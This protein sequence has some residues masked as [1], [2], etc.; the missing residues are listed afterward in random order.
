MRIVV[1]STFRFHT[2]IGSTGI[3]ETH[4]RWV[5]GFILSRKLNSITARDIGRAHREIR[6]KRAEIVATMDLLDHAGWVL[7]DAERPKDTAWLVNPKVHATYAVQ[8]AAEK[9]RRDGA[10][11]QLRVSIAELLR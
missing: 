5:A 4:A 6:G 3:S 11:E 9:A 1:P 7:P 2:E 8:A 10:R